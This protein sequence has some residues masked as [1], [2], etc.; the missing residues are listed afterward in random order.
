[1]LVFDSSA[2]VV[3]FL[4]FD[5][6]TDG[7]PKSPRVMPA[8]RIFTQERSWAALAAICALDVFLCGVCI[9]FGGLAWSWWLVWSVAAH[10]GFA[11]LVLSAVLVVSAS[12]GLAI[13]SSVPGSG[14]GRIM[15][16]LGVV[17]PILAALLTAHSR[18]LWMSA[19]WAEI[20]TGAL[21]AVTIAL[22]IQLVSID[23]ARPLITALSDMRQQ[24]AL[25]EVSVQ[26][27]RQRF[28]SI[29][30]GDNLADAL[31]LCVEE[32]LPPIEMLKSETQRLTAD[33]TACRSEISS[34]PGRVSIE[35]A[36]RMRDVIAAVTQHLSERTAIAEDLRKK[37]KP[38]NQELRR[39]RFGD[40][41][42]AAQRKGGEIVQEATALAEHTKELSAALELLIAEG[43]VKGFEGTPSSK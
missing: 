21:M 41:R 19:P 4:N 36:R 9:R 35:Q 15:V 6:A 29:M 27:G 17:P 23:S 10:Y 38:M 43:N 18:Q 30:L 14:S 13:K 24:L 34:H 3:M 37:M 28:M 12:T 40:A 25:G 31:R 33:L 16:V 11:A 42:L 8:S 26:S 5:Y 7:P 22:A 32:V 2:V 20:R 1:L 39:F